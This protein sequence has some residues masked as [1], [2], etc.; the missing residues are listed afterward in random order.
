MNRDASGDQLLLRPDD[1]PRCSEDDKATQTPSDPRSF[2][3]IDADGGCVWFP[4]TGR[5]N[6]STMAT[7]DSRD[8][9]AEASGPISR[10][11]ALAMRSGRECSSA[12][13]D[14]VA[15]KTRRGVWEVVATLNGSSP[16]SSSS[17][18]YTD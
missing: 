13:N 6:V 16:G 15:K 9:Q 17:K 8:L 10:S 12:A 1:V 11:A 2:V 3:A 4:R 5:G 7:M 18:V 14:R